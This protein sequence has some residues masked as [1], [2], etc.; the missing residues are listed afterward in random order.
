MFARQRDEIIILDIDENLQGPKMYP[1]ANFGCSIYNCVGVCR[2]IEEIWY[3]SLIFNYLI[4]LYLTYH[5]FNIWVIDING[6]LGFKKKKSNPIFMIFFQGFDSQIP[7]HVAVNSCFL[8]V[9]N[10][11]SCFKH[12]ILKLYL[13]I[14]LTLTTSSLLCRTF[15]KVLEVCLLTR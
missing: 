11:Y 14:M 9:F 3:Y 12:L 15:L 4:D 13:S 5:Q 6:V 7:F 2:Q 1:C 8:N 10:T